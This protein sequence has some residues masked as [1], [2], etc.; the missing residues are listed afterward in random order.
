MKLSN[1]IRKKEEEMTKYNIEKYNL[2][3]LILKLWI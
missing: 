3:I 1:Q 2:V